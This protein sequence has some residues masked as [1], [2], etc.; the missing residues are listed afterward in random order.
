MIMIAV[1]LAPIIIILLSSGIYS[2]IGR[3]IQRIIMGA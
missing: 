2:E 3:T 1:T